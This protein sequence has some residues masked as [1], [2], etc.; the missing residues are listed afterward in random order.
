MFLC[1]DFLERKRGRAMSTA[2]I[3]V[4]KLD[5]LSHISST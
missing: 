4:N 5:F 3:E 1:N 2:R